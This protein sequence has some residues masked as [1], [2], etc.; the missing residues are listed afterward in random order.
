ML[1]FD[2]ADRPSFVELAKLVL[3]SEDNTLQSPK[4]ENKVEVQAEENK[5]ANQ[6]ISS[7]LDN[8]QNHWES[9]EIPTSGKSPHINSTQ[10]SLPT[11]K[12]S[13]E[14]F[15][16]QQDLFKNYVD[17]NQLYV[18]FGSYILWFEAGGKKVGKVLL[19]IMY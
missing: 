11:H 8:H 2:E 10:D 19:I 1:K 9:A 15:M 17:A 12:E 18:N 4:E 13:S 14:N 6:I 3:T 5:S 16:T 7:S